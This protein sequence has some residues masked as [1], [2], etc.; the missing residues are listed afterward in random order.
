MVPTQDGTS[1]EVNAGKKRIAEMKVEHLVKYQSQQYQ[2]ALTFVQTLWNTVY[3]Q[4]LEPFQ[5][6]MEN[7]G[8]ELWKWDNCREKDLLVLLDL[9][10]MVCDDGSTD[11]NED[12]TYVCISQARKLH[13]FTHL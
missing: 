5:L 10:D 4:Y 12:E 9:I 8:S 2:S 11:T 3:G 6:A 1:T 7:K 13:N